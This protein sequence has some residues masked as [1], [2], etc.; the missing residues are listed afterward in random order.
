MK[1][2]A[3]MIQLS[4]LGQSIID[5]FVQ[6]NIN[7]EIKLKEIE[8]K[9]WEYQ[10]SKRPLELNPWKNSFH[11]IKE[12]SLPPLDKIHLSNNSKRR[13]RVIKIK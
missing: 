9:L 7:Q 8:R 3:S 6:D 1:K 5:K 11:I 13:R 2:N 10:H 4:T 12:F